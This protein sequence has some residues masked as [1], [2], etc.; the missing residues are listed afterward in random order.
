MDENVGYEQVLRIRNTGSLSCL[1]VACIHGAHSRVV[2]F[3]YCHCTQLDRGQKQRSGVEDAIFL[4]I[5]GIVSGPS[6]YLSYFLVLFDG[7]LASYSGVRAAELTHR[8][9]DLCIC[10]MINCGGRL[11]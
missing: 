6:L 2:I 4:S 1:H 3:L 7:L 10:L 8:P 9:H 5:V 11:R